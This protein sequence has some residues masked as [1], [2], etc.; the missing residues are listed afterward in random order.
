M[1]AG[2]CYNQG[3]H[4]DMKNALGSVKWTQ[5]INP[6]RSLIQGFLG[7]IAVG[8]L[9][10]LLPP[11]TAPGQS[12]S[13]VDALF[14]STSAVCVTGLVVVDTGSH[15]T[16]FGQMVVLALFQLGGLGIMVW[17]TGALVWMGSRVGLKGRVLLAAHVPGMTLSEVGTLAGGIAA[18]ALICEGVGAL[19]LWMIWAGE[20][21]ALKALYYGIFHS[22]SAFCNA[23]FCLWPD[24][25]MS[26]AGNPAVNLVI[27]ALAIIGSLGFLAAKESVFL[28]LRRPG[29]RLSLHSRLV[30]SVTL[31][32]TLLGAAGIL[33]FESLNQRTL[34]AMDREDAVVAAFFMSVNRTSGFATV[35][36]GDMRSETLQLLMM[37]MFVG[38]SP[39]STA[40]GIKTT[41]FAILLLTALCT[42][43]RR[44]EVTA[45]GRR[46]PHER[47]LQAVAM[48]VVALTVVMALGLLVNSLEPARFERVLFE[49]M[50][51]A[52]T[53]GLSTGITPGLTPV[54]K[55]VLCMAMLLGRVGPF[56][57]ALALL[58]RA[59]PAEIRFPRGEVSI[60]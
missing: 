13:F 11:C 16:R 58:Q 54:S 55:L 43:A 10:L 36:V 50:S 1:Q 47:V 41:T 17:T 12:T 20:L 5:P 25:L 59:R 45:F 23:G 24:S 39:G 53:V 40:G 14:T 57:L 19:L 8:T 15:F 26:Q 7:L 18:F 6:A 21:G 32:L 60:G 44:D 35:E 28:L 22:I 38:G 49:V 42:L 34:G 46:I 48:S 51:A 29:F 56:S 3:G 31:L 27:A 2:Q 4:R 9:L 52:A 37:L 33:G 30:L